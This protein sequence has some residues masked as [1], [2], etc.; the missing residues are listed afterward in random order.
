MRPLHSIPLGAAAAACYSALKSAH[1]LLAVFFVAQRRS[2]PL[3]F[4]SL[5]ECLL[6]IFALLL[7]RQTTLALLQ[8]PTHT[9]TRT[10]TCINGHLDCRHTLALTHLRTLHPPTH[11]TR[12]DI[13]D[14][15]EMCKSDRVTRRYLSRQHRFKA[16]PAVKQYPTKLQKQH[17]I[18][19]R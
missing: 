12:Q 11:L 3:R 13:C 7:S 9:R 2:C 16:P 15:M 4:A 1:Q 6:L 10:H 17:R 5:Q 18:A 8:S 19:A 14:W